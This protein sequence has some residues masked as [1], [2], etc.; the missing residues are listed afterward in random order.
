MEMDFRHLKYS[1]LEYLLAER[2]P[3][4]VKYQTL[5][6]ILGKPSSD[7]EVR[8]WKRERDA[9]PVVHDLRARQNPDGS[10]ACIP[11]IHLHH[12][13]FH[14]MLEMGYGMEDPTVRRSVENLL[15]YQVPTGGYRHPHGKMI[16]PS[17]SRDR[18]TPCVTGYVTNALMDL[19]LTN[20]PSVQRALRV[21][22]QGQKENG[23]WICD[24][25]GKRAPYCIWSG[26]PWV[27][28]CLAHAGLIKKTHAITRRAL[29][30]FAKHKDKIIRHGYHRDHYYR[31]DEALL[32]PAL[33]ATGL[34]LRHP[35]VGD[36][37]ESFVEKQQ[38]EGFWQFKAGGGHHRSNPK[39]DDAWYT[40]EAVVALG[41]ATGTETVS[42]RA[43]RGM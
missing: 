25:V 27:F 41:C 15:D 17:T 29:A 22:H 28:A 43:C 13:Y 12:Y 35:L 39:A 16:D 26:T 20:H 10:F 38:P 14:R 19:G 42:D 34:T 4:W 32:I 1:P 9:S 30:V 36:L 2:Q 24:H 11:W 3:A 21:M 37:Y 8:K 5:V 7:P 6:R 23:G 31:C 40:I 33:R 18:W